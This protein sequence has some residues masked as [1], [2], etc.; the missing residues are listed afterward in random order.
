MDV[1]SFATF[2]AASWNP[3]NKRFRSHCTTSMN[4]SFYCFCCLYLIIC[5]GQAAYP[6]Y[7]AY[8]YS[9]QMPQSAP[10]A[11]AYGAYPSTY[12]SQVWNLISTYICNI[13]LEI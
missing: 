7:G 5:V 4:Y 10:Q 3:H 12:P 1:T 13:L 9:H 6:A 8:D 2:F 11:A